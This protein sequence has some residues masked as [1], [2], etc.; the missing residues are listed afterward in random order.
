MRIK[1]VVTA[2]CAA[3]MTMTCVSTNTMAESSRISVPITMDSA[4][5]NTVNGYVAEVSYAPTVLS[6]VLSDTDILGEDCYAVN[7]ID[8]GYLTADKTSEGKIIVGW[9]DKDFY[10]FEDNNKL[11]H[12]EFEVLSDTKT[13]DTKI[14]T[15]IYQIARYSDV[16]VDGEYS[17]SSSY[18]VNNNISKAFVPFVSDN[19]SSG[20]AVEVSSTD[21]VSDNGFQLVNETA[22][23][24]VDYE[25][26]Q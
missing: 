6:P 1:S 12:I 25:E 18:K 4:I 10:S 24:A 17:Y 14:D 8:R 9:A 23:N 20:A 15:K 26:V 2:L 3:I 21:D 13:Q 7:D 5:T 19:V 11:A 16:M 22:E